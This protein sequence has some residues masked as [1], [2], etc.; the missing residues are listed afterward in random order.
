MQEVTLAEDEVGGLGSLSRT[1]G[2]DK[3][4]DYGWR[5]LPNPTQSCG[6]VGEAAAPAYQE[7]FAALQ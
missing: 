2:V 5:R 7:C 4:C 3:L 6:L 1:L